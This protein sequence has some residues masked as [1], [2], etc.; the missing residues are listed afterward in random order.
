[1]VVGRLVLFGVEGNCKMRFWILNRK[2]KEDD[3]IEIYSSD[4]AFETKKEAIR[5][6][7]IYK[8][9]VISVQEVSLS[10]EAMLSSLTTLFCKGPMFWHWAIFKMVKERAPGVS[11][12]ET[13][14]SE[15]FDLEN[16]NV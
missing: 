7:S 14:S 9:S 16:K 12:H 8:K 2:N 3:S 1:M 6:A 15:Y 11:F 4:G 5:E 10:Q 13:I